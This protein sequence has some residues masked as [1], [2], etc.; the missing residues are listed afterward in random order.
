MPRPITQSEQSC[1]PAAA[2]TVSMPASPRMVVSPK[3][4][5]LAEDCRLAEA[6]GRLAAELCAEEDH[7][8]RE[9]DRKDRIGVHELSRRTA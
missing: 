3:D 8:Q 1:L 9:Q 5:Q 2:A 7:G 4:E 6:G